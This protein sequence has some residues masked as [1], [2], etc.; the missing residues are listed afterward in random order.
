MHGMSNTRADDELATLPGGSEPSHHVGS[1]RRIL[2]FLERSL[3]LVGE[4]SSC[5]G[6]ACGGILLGESRRRAVPDRSRGREDTTELYSP[7][8]S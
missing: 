8:S 5:Y 4:T 3:S 7:A 2:A 6:G 1:M